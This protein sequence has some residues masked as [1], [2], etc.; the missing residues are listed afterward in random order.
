MNQAA[1]Q[2]KYGLIKVANFTIDQLNLG[3]KIIIQKRIQHIT[4]GNLLLLKDLLNLKK[5]NL[6][7]RDFN[8]E[9]CEY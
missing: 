5:Q 7:M 8:I 9:K 1:N 2:T 3:Y 6:Q 4:K